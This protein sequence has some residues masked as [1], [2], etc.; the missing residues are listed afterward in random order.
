MNCQSIDHAIV[1]VTVSFDMYLNFVREA[2]MAGYRSISQKFGTKLLRYGIR[3]DVWSNLKKVFRDKD[4]LKDV[5]HDFS[6]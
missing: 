1:A 4:A 3:K 2:K 6:H 5:K